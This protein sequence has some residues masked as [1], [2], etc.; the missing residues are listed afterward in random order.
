MQSRLPWN[1]QS[2]CISLLSTGITD[3]N[4]YAWSYSHFLSPSSRRGQ[5][6]SLWQARFYHNTKHVASSVNAFLSASSEYWKQQQSF[7]ELLGGASKS[8]G[9][10]YTWETLNHMPF[11]GL[12]TNCVNEAHLLPFLIPHISNRSCNKRILSHPWGTDLDMPRLVS[13]LGPSSP[14]FYQL[15]A[16]TFNQDWKT[17]RSLKKIGERKKSCMKLKTEKMGLERFPAGRQFT[18]AISPERLGQIEHS[19]TDRV[20]GTY[21]GQV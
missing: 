1:L 19:R 3:R 8:E 17:R 15:R 11:T 5:L 12:S 4:H 10:Y 20:R 6:N 13:S 2:S 7:R 14:F 21:Q 16:L 18:W 9:M